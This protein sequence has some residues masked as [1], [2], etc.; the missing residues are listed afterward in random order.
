MR[1]KHDS[2]ESAQQNRLPR[3]SYGFNLDKLYWHAES[4]AMAR[5]G[6]LGGEDTEDL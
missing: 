6:Q 2:A 4:E 3:L 5:S 1:T